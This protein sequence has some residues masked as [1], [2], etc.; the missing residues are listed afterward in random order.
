VGGG[1]KKFTYQPV[2]ERLVIKNEHIIQFTDML[3]SDEAPF[4]ELS[5]H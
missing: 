5:L 1:G 2:L 4:E 3:C